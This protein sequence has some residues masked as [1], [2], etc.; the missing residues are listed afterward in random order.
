MMF[1]LFRLLAAFAGAIACHSTW[2][3][4][5]LPNDAEAPPPDLTFATLYYQ[6]NQFKDLYVNS[7][8]TTSNPSLDV[9]LGGIRL[10][11]SY[12]VGDLPGISYVQVAAGQANPGGSMAA[13]S[14]DSGL[15]DTAFA[16]AIWPYANR[17]T[18]TFLGVAAYLIV[19]TGSY[20]KQ[21]AVNLGENRYRADL[22]LGYQTQFTENLSG[23]LAFDT[24]WFGP[25]NQFNANNAQLTQKPLY[26]TQ[27]GPIY[28]FNKM[29]T[30]GANYLYVVGGESSINGQS[31]NLLVQTQRYYVT[32][33]THLS[34][35]R[36]ALQYGNDI[37]TRNGFQESRRFMVRFSKAF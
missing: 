18:R 29:F 2:A 1:K 6:N 22:Q 27:L 17:E 4:D 3:I 33:L 15:T 14:N 12:R 28:R 16:T 9:N 21:R 37:E 10:A 25:N 8:K 11:R 32:L 34:V 26:T 23:M 35:G 31:Q 30:L 7:K 13:L 5:L 24:M 20:D 36:I 19:P